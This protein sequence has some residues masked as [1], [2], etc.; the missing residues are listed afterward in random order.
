MR[1]HEVAV[2]RLDDIVPGTGVCALVGGEQVAVFRVDERVHAIANLDPFSNASVLSRGIV[3]DLKGELVVASPVY[4]QHFSLV[5]GRCVEDAAVRVPVYAAR[6]E[7]DMVI[8][9]AHREVATT[10]CYCGVGCG[11]LARVENGRIESVRGDPGHPANSGRLCTKGLALHKAD[12]AFRALYPEVNGYRASWDQAL[13]YVAQTIST[14][15]RLHGPD[16]IGLYVSG[17]FLTEDYYVFNK[18]A[19]GLIG[20]NNIDTNS[21]LCMASAVAG[22]KQTLGADAPPA[23]YEDLDSAECVFIAGSNTAWAHPVLF[24]RIEEAKPR[25]L[26][27]V[28]PRKTET[29]RAATLHLPI[30]PGTDVVLFNGM[31]HVMLREGWCDERYIHAHTEGFDAVRALVASTTPAQAAALCGIGERDLIEAARVFALSKST[32]SLYCQGLNQS[33]SG[34]AKN[35]ALINLH[36]ATGQIGK[37]GAGPFSL[38][39]QPNAMGGREVGGMANLLCGHRELTNPQHRKEIAELW[40]VPAI[41]QKPGKTAVEMFEAV[42]AGEIKVLWIACTNPAQSLP[43]QSLVREALERAALVIVQDAYRNTETARYAHVF[44]PA[45]AWGEK[46]GTMTNSERRISRVR[47]MLGPPG[48]AR[49]DWRIAVDVARR[50]GGASLFPYE[51]PEQIFDE[52]RETTRGRDLDITGISYRLLDERGPQQWPCPEGATEGRKRLYADGAFATPNGRARFVRTPYRPVVEEVDSQYPL[53]LT[54]GRLRDQWHSMA[55]TGTV[56]RLFGHDPEPRVTMHPD[57]LNGWE[58]HIVRLS[59]RRGELYVRAAADP[60][61][62]RGTVFLPMHWGSRFL[63]TG[64]NELTVGALDPSSRQPELKHC[65]VRVEE[66][67]LPWQLV[68][69]GDGDIAALTERLEPLM[70]AAPYAARTLIG[71]DVP[72]VRLE[73]AAPD[74]V[75][76]LEEIDAAFGLDGGEVLRHED[77]RIALKDE[78]IRAVRLVGDIRP[79]A[80]LREL[81]ERPGVAEELRRYSRLPTDK[82]AM[83][84]RT[85][86]NC[87]D[88]SE[89]EIATF[90]SL[91][92]LQSALKCGTNCGSCLP[93]LRKQL[94]A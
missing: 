12:P 18:L 47:A 82:P 36:L 61:L 4:K 17:Q 39:G 77:A 1:S 86:C 72:G 25:H 10:C 23:C 35:A 31:L 49:A 94:A 89:A 75:D 57:D 38:T 9:E 63:G 21:R 11:V 84:G 20:T 46:E 66:A 88:V 15:V 73:L 29:A 16:A 58:G 53:R 30:V 51:T 13:D 80:W 76:V 45:A 26:I 19:K 79:E 2:C 7:Q 62:P 87:F 42:R 90:K 54:T 64:I 27:V 60:G 32:L 71:R 93:E 59:S 52:H 92:E 50:M 41:P 65:A 8:V 43:N 81:W 83:R 6:V 33:S 44:L 74:A 55:R 22:Y 56:A 3:G 85:V 24:R 68:A 48:E 69:F 70:R 14:S 67:R 40:G 34:T 5:S 78:R 37:P 28:D 91:D